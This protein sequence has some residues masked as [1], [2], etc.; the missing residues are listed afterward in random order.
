[1]ITVIFYNRVYINLCL[2][3]ESFL[4]KPPCM[5]AIL[6]IEDEPDIRENVREILEL[7]NYRVFTAENGKAGIALAL[8]EH[9]DLVVSDITMPVIDGYGVLHILRKHP[10]T[11]NI[12]FIF[13][14]SRDEVQ[15]LRRAMN[16]GAN[17]YII[18]PFEGSDLL[19]TVEQ[20]LKI[21][22]ENVEKHP[23]PP[24]TT[25][26]PQSAGLQESGQ[27]LAQ[28]I[29]EGDVA[30]FKKKQLIY[31]EG[32]VPRF[33]YYINSGKVR[34]YKSHED[35][36]DLVMNLHVAGDYLGYTAVIQNTF[37]TETAEATEDAEIVPIPRKEFEKLMDRDAAVMRQFMNLLAADLVEKEQQFLGAAYNTLRKKVAGALLA[38]GRKYGKGTEHFVINMSRN[39]MATIAGTAPESLIRTL[40]EFKQE[41]LIEIDNGIITIIDEYKL[42][43]LLR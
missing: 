25:E 43:H 21:D 16:M 10:Q 9:I 8:Q 31:K 18:K 40:T 3:T 20:Q 22:N 24:T 23:L 36:K 39:E 19:R 17:D 26:Q 27:S 37:Y 33:V 32:S 42:E 14:S 1:M 13:L 38:L 12:P 30:E 35:G 41:K 6:V 5:A 7:A 28:L 29:A 4:F 2:E 11:K 34:T 15:N